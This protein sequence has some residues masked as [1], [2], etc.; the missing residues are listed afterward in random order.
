MDGIK[1]AVKKRRFFIL[2]CKPAPFTR[3]LGS[4]FGV[5]MLFS[6]RARHPEPLL[7]LTM[8]PKPNISKPSIRRLNLTNRARF[9]A[10]FL[11]PLFF[12]V[13]A[14][15]IAF[16]AK[17][18]YEQGDLDSAEATSEG[19]IFAEDPNSE[20]ARA[21]LLR[22]YLDFSGNLPEWSREAKSKGLQFSGLI[23]DEAKYR[24]FEAEKVG[25]AVRI[26]F[27]RSNRSFAGNFSQGEIVPLSDDKNPLLDAKAKALI[28]LFSSF[29]N[30]RCSELARKAIQSGD[31]EN[32]F[33]RGKSAVVFSFYCDEDQVDRKLTF[34]K[35]DMILRECEDVYAGGLEVAYTYNGYMTVGDTRQP[36]EISLR[37][38]SGKDF[39]IQ[40]SELRANPLAPGHS[41]LTAGS[42]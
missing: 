7:H 2:T 25:D 27:L 11:Y 22:R 15:F 21:E 6:K 9:Y 18:M 17:N 5:G 41:L 32:D 40:L 28:L 36:D 1:I 42:R 29:G 39:R 35:Q 30:P 12:I 24:A 23:M 13:V 14:L 3:E 16:K 20:E 4:K 38:G 33:W 34:E 37:T 26:R 10:W 8:N 19:E 31:W